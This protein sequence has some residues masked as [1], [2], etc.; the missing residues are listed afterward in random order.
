MYR[1]LIVDDEEFIVNGL[2]EIFSSMKNLDL[3]VYKAYS[4]EE[5]I[6]WLNRTRMDIVLTDI[7]MPEIDG[8]ELLDE[9]LGSWPRCKVIFL[10]G[11]NDFEY[12]YKAIQ[13]NGVSYILK[14]EDLEKVVNA[15]KNAIREIQNE[16]NTEDLI[17]KAKEQIN[18]ALD[19]FQKEYFIQL[20][21]DDPSLNI[22][23]SQ[24][25]QL[26]IS[27]YPDKPV[28]LLLGHVDNIPA[29]LSYW[30]KIQYLYS[31]RLII[32]Q[33]LNANI[34]SV[35]VM[36]E[37]YRFVLFI[38]PRELLTESQAQTGMITGYGKTISFLK[39]TLEVI[40]TNCRE[41]LN[42]S[43]SFAMSGEP[44]GW[45]AVS[46]KYYSLSQL[47]N[48][49]IGTGIEMLLID[50]EIKNDILN[51]KSEVPEL[52][53]DTEALEMLIR[54]RR[55]D[56]LELYLESGQEDKFFETLSELINPLKIIKSKNSNVAI[57]AYYKISLNILSYINRC[58]LTEKIAFRLDQN[59]LMR[60]DMYESWEE[61]VDYIYQLSNVIFRLQS[62][63]K[64]KRADNAINY[65]QE[66][67][68]AHLGEDLSLV[69]L[70][71]QVYLNP[72]YLSRLYKQVTGTNLS[73]FIDSSRIE[74]AKELLERE[75][76]K[77]HE[78][79]KSVGYE[80]AA[81]FTRFFRKITGRSPQEYHDAILSSRHK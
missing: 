38:Q 73:D 16:I 19:L 80:T 22:T 61:A 69:R 4:G 21:H 48:Y 32:G 79:S 43:I 23:Q 9:I 6:E 35:Y 25:E 63:E 17:K 47:L 8:M 57:E 52:E 30:E 1:L 37:S 14:T 78:V 20:L 31:V 71:E 13:H 18:M 68:E 46:K 67:I 75:N 51:T 62:D 58:K 33:Y 72:S 74:K 49:R 76:V 11:H 81:S 10:S 53:A 42:A 34:R 66:F 55:L 3:D 54:H 65:I 59:R 60:I 77:I 50:N 28:I 56:M 39:G 27:M 41:S 2:Y 70:A 29:E 44:C 5:A 24:F 36:D 12:V 7:S 26:E 15:V 45:E 40:Q 64:K